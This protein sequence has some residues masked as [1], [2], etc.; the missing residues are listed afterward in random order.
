MTATTQLDTTELR[1][2]VRLLGDTLGEVIRTTVGE[3]LFQSIESIRQTSK[4]ATDA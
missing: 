4:S 2:N 3:S 1:Q